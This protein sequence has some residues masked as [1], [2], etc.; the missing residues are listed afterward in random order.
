MVVG[1]IMTHAILAEL[2]KML[3]RAPKTSILQ[4]KW[5]LLQGILNIKFSKKEQ[6]KKSHRFFA[7]Y[8]FRNCQSEVH[9][10]RYNFRKCQ[11]EV[12]LAR[13]N[14]RKCQSEVHLARYNLRKCQS[15]VH[16]ARYNFNVAQR[17]TLLGII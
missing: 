15:E 17:Y 14:L 6:Q 1:Y 12:H 16:L 9:L 7:R 11:S 10:A 3:Y 2:F 13:Y 5:G 8:N 4:G